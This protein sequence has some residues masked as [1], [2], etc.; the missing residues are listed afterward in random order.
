MN[1]ESLNESSDESS[2]YN[3]VKMFERVLN[4]QI[5]DCLRIR[6]NVERQS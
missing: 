6:C 3:A 4:H 5:D 1:H 2:E